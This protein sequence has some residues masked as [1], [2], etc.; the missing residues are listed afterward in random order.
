MAPVKI[1]V[2]CIKKKK[3]HGSILKKILIERANLTISKKK[4]SLIPNHRK[5]TP[6][7]KKKEWYKQQTKTQQ[8]DKRRRNTHYL[9][10]A[11]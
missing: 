9:T 6:L 2:Q 8:N 11:V 10:N 1:M 7:K 3:N 5:G 4:I